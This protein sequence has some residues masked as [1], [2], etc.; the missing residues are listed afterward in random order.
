M[1][2]I[3]CE[4]GRLLAW[5]HF[6]CVPSRSGSIDCPTSTGFEKKKS[7]SAKSTRGA[8]AAPGRRAPRA[9]PGRA[10]R[11]QA[12][13]RVPSAAARRSQSDLRLLPEVV[14]L[15]TCTFTV[16]SFSLPVVPSPSDSSGSTIRCS[17]MYV[18]HNSLCHSLS[19]HRLCAAPLH[20]CPS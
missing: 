8:D 6:A 2:Y 5:A 1:I 10:R 3:S 20:W 9:G 4:S 19:L 16:S 15:L 7:T 18:L 17:L 12:P 13:V 11:R 14:P